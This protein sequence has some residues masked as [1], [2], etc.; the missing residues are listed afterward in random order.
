M[1]PCFPARLV[2]V[3]LHGSLAWHGIEKDNGHQE[4]GAACSDLFTTR[5]KIRGVGVG[6]QISLLFVVIIECEM[7]V[8]QNSKHTYDILI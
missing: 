8:F 6:E 1:G 5:E 7:H 4:P 2:A 3:S